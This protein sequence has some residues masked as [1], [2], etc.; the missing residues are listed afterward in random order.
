MIAPWP[1]R[2]TGGAFYSERLYSELVEDFEITVLAD[3]DEYNSG[4]KSSE[5]GRLKVVRTWRPGRLAPFEALVGALRTSAHIYHIQFEYRMFGSFFGTLMLPFIIAC[6]RLFTFKPV[7]LTLHGI[8][9]PNFRLS[10]LGNT[11]FQ[12]LK[13]WPLPGLYEK[14]LKLFYR[15]ICLLASSIT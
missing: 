11:H 4:T 12:L 13:Y 2:N 5:E 15:F 6:L 9:A 7:L 14:S 3:R 8:P 1:P 10:E